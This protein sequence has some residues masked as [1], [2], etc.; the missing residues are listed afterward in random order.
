MSGSELPQTPQ[1]SVSS[2][3]WIS[4]NFAN[5]CKSK[6]EEKP[7]KAP[8]DYEAEAYLAACHDG[9]NEAV[10]GTLNTLL[11]I[12]SGLYVSENKIEG[13]IY[14]QSESIRHDYCGDDGKSL[15]RPSPR[16]FKPARIWTSGCRWP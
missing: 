9:C 1:I 8:K 14:G 15:L 11:Y 6:I 10:R 3:T 2:R 4:N 13:H 16:L 7:D 12:L 5:H